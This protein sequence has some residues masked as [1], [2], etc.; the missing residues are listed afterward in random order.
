MAM[1]ATVG[2]FPTKMLLSQRSKQL[3]SS[4]PNNMPRRRFSASN[5][6]GRLEAVRPLAAQELQLRSGKV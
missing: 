6:A 2:Y 3:C 4:K 1:H 5:E